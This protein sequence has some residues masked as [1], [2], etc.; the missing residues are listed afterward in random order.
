MKQSVT[1]GRILYNDPMPAA[2]KSSSPVP[3]KTTAAKTVKKSTV[4]SRVKKTAVKKAAAKPRTKAVKKTVTPKKKTV[5]K[6]A[7]TKKVPT[8]KVPAKKSVAS[9]RASKKTAEVVQVPTNVPLRSVEK[10]E[11]LRSE[12]SLSWQQSM[13]SI[14]YV[15]GFCFLLIGATYASANVFMPAAEIN[16]AAVVAQSTTIQLQTILNVESKLPKELAGPTKVL[17]TLTHVEPSS[18]RYYVTHQD[19]KKVSVRQ[20]TESLQNDKFS[21]VLEPEKLTPGQ[22]E[23]QIEYVTKSAAGVAGNKKTASVA[24]FIVPAPIEKE[25]VAEVS[26]SVEQAETVDVQQPKSAEENSKPEAI[27]KS[28]TSPVVAPVN[29]SP[30]QSTST[31]EVS[32]E[33]STDTSSVSPEAPKET[34]AAEKPAVSV[35][36]P[37]SEF[38]LYLKETEVSGVLTLPVVKADSLRSLELYARPVTSLNSRFLTR[39]SERLDGKV[40]VVNTQSFLPNGKY[41]LY[42]R[43][44]DESGKE[45]TTKSLV[46]T[47]KNAATKPEDSNEYLPSD[48]TTDS[49]VDEDVSEDS[50]PARDIAPVEVGVSVM[51]SS[52]APF[53]VQ[54]VGKRMLQ[55]D[56]EAIATLLM[57]YGSARQSGDEVLI[58]AARDSLTKKKVELAN[59]ALID[60]ELTGISDDVIAHI[61]DELS[62]LQ[63]RVDTFEQIR[64]EK[65]GGNSATDSDGDGIPDYDEVNLYKTNPN[66]S[67]TDN[68]GFTDG[69]EIIRGFNPLDDT[70]EV[71]IEFESPKE[72][73]GLVRENDFVIR[74]VIPSV[75]TMAEVADG[76]VRTE[77]RGRGLPN[78]FVTLYIFSTPTIVTIKTDADGS[79]VYTL[80]KE[81]E[82]GTHDVFVA[83]T[84]NT[85]AIVAQSNPFSFVKEAQAFTPVDASTGDIVGGESVTETVAKNSYNAVIGLG[86]LAFGLILIMLGISLRTKDEEVFTGNDTKKTT[87]GQVVT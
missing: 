16:N 63:N 6:R 29:D 9:K 18:V 35:S 21:F 72:S 8:K 62:D 85:G 26:E 33:T 32:T 70:A 25:P 49:T 41:E 34:R 73:V 40:F 23:L 3:K 44:T 56:S 46:V 27:K 81:L 36:N 67:D 15:S 38:S 71:V 84:D 75:S 66:E 2:K 1:A 77:I 60:R 83:L 86:V 87:E 45:L 47:V 50:T 69:I 28:P 59:E 51:S 24:R 48:E 55:R 13:H 64:K 78:S 4:S 57:N 20:Q 74:E 22:Y 19:T 7:T 42:A 12:L 11:V 82:D 31:T 17:F 58:A 65:S 79:F 10:A 54:E 68:D 80:D 5:A 39:A 30:S 52:T 53:E 76:T 37:V 61:S 14:A 43:G